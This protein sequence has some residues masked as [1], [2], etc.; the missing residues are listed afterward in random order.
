MTFSAAMLSGYYMDAA[1]S[2]FVPVILSGIAGISISLRI[3][4]FSQHLFAF[5]DAELRV[6]PFVRVGTLPSVGQLEKA[7]KSGFSLRPAFEPV[8]TARLLIS[9]HNAVR[10]AF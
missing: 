1:D 3:L 5:L 4:F 10:L 8:E 6:P 2:I 9:Q 7:F